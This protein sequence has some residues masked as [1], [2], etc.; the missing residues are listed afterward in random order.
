MIT[1]VS[2]KLE[3]NPDY[4]ELRIGTAP[5]STHIHPGSV[6][7]SNGKRYKVICAEPF[8]VDSAEMRFI[9]E[10]YGTPMVIEGIWVYEQF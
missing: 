6:V 9:M 10:T 5:F 7:V 3:N 8:C 1:L 2:M 4:G